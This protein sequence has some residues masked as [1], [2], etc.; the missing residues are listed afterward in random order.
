MD[1]QK[2]VENASPCRLRAEISNKSGSAVIGGQ[3]FEAE[4]TVVGQINWYRIADREGAKS[5]KN[6]CR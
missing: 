4:V 1:G 5:S 2:R 6:S 3:G